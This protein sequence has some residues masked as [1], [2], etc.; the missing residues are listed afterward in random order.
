[1]NVML[2][3]DLF[4][5][6]FARAGLVSDVELFENAVASARRAQHRWAAATAAARGFA[7]DHSIGTARMTRR[8]RRTLSEPWSRARAVG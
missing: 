4:E 7:R 3:H 6:A 8:H 2:S 1:V 5:G